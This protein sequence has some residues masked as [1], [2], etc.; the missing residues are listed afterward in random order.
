MELRTN[1]GR[2]TIL[3]FTPGGNIEGTLEVCPS[4]LRIFLGF[5]DRRFVN[6][7]PIESRNRTTM[8]PMDFG[9]LMA[10]SDGRNFFVDANAES[11]FA[12]CLRRHLG[13][14]E[15]ARIAG[16]VACGEV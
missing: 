13:A 3:F 2:D 1:G 8:Y 14:D 9:T 5:D 10:D 11:L 12:E 7:E 4:R 6:V 16:A 15:S